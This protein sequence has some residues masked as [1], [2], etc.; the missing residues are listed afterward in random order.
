VP[1]GKVFFGELAGYYAAERPDTDTDQVFVVLKGQR[2]GRPLSAA[3]VD[4]VLS[5]A[6]RRAGLAHATCHELRH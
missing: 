2:R 5:G 4:E 6:R 1:V 3:G